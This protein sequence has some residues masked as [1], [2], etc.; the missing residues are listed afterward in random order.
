MQI[1]LH[2]IITLLL[3]PWGGFVMMSPMM[4]AAPGFQ[5]NK[6]S[7]LSAM[8]FLGYP[9]IIFAILKLF[10]FHYFGIAAN[11]WLLWSSVIIALIIL[12]SG[13]PKLL[14]NISRGIPNSG[15]F[16]SGT[17]VY[18][19]GRII[20]E[21]SPE[22][23][24]TLEEDSR[25]A[26][27]VHY[28]FYDGKIVSGADPTTF[29]SVDIVSQEETFSPC[30]W[31]DNQHV[32]IDGKVLED[33]DAATFI[34]IS[35]GYGRDASKVYY[36]DKILQGANPKTFYFITETIS[37]DDSSLFVFHKRVTEAVDLETFEI[38]K[39]EEGDFCKD[40]NHVYI[41][42]YHLDDPLLKIPDAD[43]NTFLPIGRSYAHDHSNVYFYGYYKGKKTKI[44]K[45][46]DVNPDTFS[47]GYDES[48]GSEAT[49][50]KKYFMYGELVRS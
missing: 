19:N 7:I 9:V 13:T 47:V 28:V 15:Y 14:Y 5:D 24:K 31:K 16:K 27:D 46:E 36:R 20:P 4:F 26:V 29:Q 37:R 48:T 25:Y 2:I 30:Y 17:S 35:Q 42:F 40:K 32:Y 33:G 8:L 41:I 38:V 21:A 22:T 6:R 50:G 10:N 34:C 23:F 43:P 1:V 44:L 3:A 18:L 39:H 12:I 45:L 11:T 49:D